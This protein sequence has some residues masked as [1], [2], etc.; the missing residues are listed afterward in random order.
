MNS[1]NIIATEFSDAFVIERRS[2]NDERGSFQRFFCDTELNQIWGQR[3]ICQANLSYNLEAG[4]IRG[5][6]GQRPP[7]AEKKLVTCLQGSVFDVIV[8][9]RVDS[10]TF[11]KYQSF[12]LSDDNHLALL[13][14]QG[15]VH[16]F[17]A[18]ENNSTL[19]YLH[20]APYHKESEF[21][22]NIHDPELNINWP[23]P[24]RS[25]SE[26]DRKHPFLKNLEGVR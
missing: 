1:L 13:I 12:E 20:D 17:Q 4:T 18:L 3:N 15:F 8:D 5:F 21:G 6:H 25:I 23:L 7:Y 11:G 19:I 10:E 26:R 16:A 24:I 2:L 14:P 9:V 22:L